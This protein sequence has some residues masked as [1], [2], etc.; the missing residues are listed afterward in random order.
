[1][2]KPIACS[3]IADPHEVHCRFGH[4]SLSLGQKPTFFLCCRLGHPSLSLLKYFLGVEVMRN[5]QGNLLSQWE[6]V[7]YMLAETG[8]L[9]V[10]P[11][12]THM[13]PNVQLSKEGQLFEDPKRYKRLVGKLRILLI[14]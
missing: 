11:C 14:Q 2:L 4:L 1:M 8:K 5:K 7:L 3:K 10:R 12:N 6:Y 13:A 9:G